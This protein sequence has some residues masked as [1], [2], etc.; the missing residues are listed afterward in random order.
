MEELILKN[1]NLIYAI[2]K[3]FDKYSSKEDLFQAGCIGMMM[4]YKNYDE[5]SG[6]KFTTYA[7]SYILGEMKKLV[8][9]DKGIKINRSV[10]LVSLKI[11]KAKVYLTQQL[12]REPSTK[13][14][15]IYLEI[16]E[17][18]ICDSLNSNMTIYSIDAP[19]KDGENITLQDTISDNQNVG[20]DDLI[21]LKNVLSSLSPFEKQIIEDRYVRD[22]TQ[23]QIAKH[24][25][26]S[27]VQVSRNEKK[28]LSKLRNKMVA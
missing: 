20:L 23:Q 3:Y 10:Q 1:R 6:V 13:E 14:L 7:Y 18:I 12:M 28:V 27:Q 26:I 19:L 2:A 9:E 11:E 22:L 17:E 25:G 8:R 4:A 16:P 5:N 15:S 21:E 24:L